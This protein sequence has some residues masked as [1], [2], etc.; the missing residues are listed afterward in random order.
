[1]PEIPFH[2]ASPQEPTRSE[3]IHNLM[4]RLERE[5]LDY[6][7][8]LP[9]D[10]F[11]HELMYERESISFQMA[12]QEIREWL[13][14][15]GMSLTARGQRG[16]G[17]LIEEKKD[18]YRAINGY[19][20]RIRN[21]ARRGWLLAVNTTPEGLSITEQRK[22]AKQAELMGMHLILLQKPRTFRDLIQKER[23]DLLT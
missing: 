15:R 17:F 3:R 13:L 1:M 19:K 18:N 16:K 7:K 6:G 23:P 14:K 8:F 21:G 12:V 9:I 4:T 20:K 22:L 5:G 2:P 11:D 10:V